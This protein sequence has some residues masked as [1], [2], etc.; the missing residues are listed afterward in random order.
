[1]GAPPNIKH[2]DANGK[3]LKKI[4]TEYGAT[5][6]AGVNLGIG[7]DPDCNV[8]ATNFDKRHIALYAPTGKLLATATSG[9][10][11]AKDV[12]VGPNGDVYV[13]DISTRKITRFAVDRSKP[14]NAI[15]PGSVTVSKGK[16]TIKYTLAGVACP[17]EVSAVATLS[18]AVKGK[19]AMKVAAGRTTALTIPAKGASGKAQFTIVLKTNGRSTTQ[20]A[21]V[22][23]TVK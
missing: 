21:A 15:V 6:G 4:N 8:W 12:A 20:T 9:D 13:F 2:Y 19:A 5:S 16:A 7:V 1:M 10:M 22:N 17:A 3:L 11:V 14:A 23:V 18:G